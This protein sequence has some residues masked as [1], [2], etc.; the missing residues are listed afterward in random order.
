MKNEPTLHG[1]WLCT[2]R[3]AGRM[4]VSEGDTR[5]EAFSGWLSLMERRIH[6]QYLSGIRSAI[7][8]R[9]NSGTCRHAEED[10]DG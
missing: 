5:E 8:R 4:L 7:Q 10:A 1:S 9:H 6:T 2:G 3:V